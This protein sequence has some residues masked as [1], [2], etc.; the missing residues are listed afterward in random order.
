MKTQKIIRPKALNIHE[1]N[2][3]DGGSKQD[4]EE[5]VKPQPLSFHL[6]SGYE[7]DLQQREKLV[8]PTNMLLKEPLFQQKIFSSETSFSK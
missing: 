6:V 4:E 5:I 8:L 3:N 2:E 7:S 1:F